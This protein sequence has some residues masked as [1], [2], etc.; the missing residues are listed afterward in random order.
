MTCAPFEMSAGRCQH[1]FML[2][3]VAFEACAW[4]P[5]RL[6]RRKDACPAMVYDPCNRGAWRRIGMGE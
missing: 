2:R 1:T 4:P 6:R 5:V 3:R